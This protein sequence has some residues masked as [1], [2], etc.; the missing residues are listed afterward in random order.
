MIARSIDPS[1]LPSDIESTMGPGLAVVGT[2]GSPWDVARRRVLLPRPLGDSFR[3]IVRLRSVAIYWFVNQRQYYHKVT[4]LSTLDSGSH[5]TT[6]PWS[7]I[8]YPHADP[9]TNTIHRALDIILSG[10]KWWSC[11]IYLGGLIEF[12]KKEAEHVSHVDRVLLLLRGQGV[13]LRYVCAGFSQDDIPAAPNQTGADLRD[14][15]PPERFARGPQPQDPKA[16]P[17]IYRDVQR[18]PTLRV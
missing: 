12:S 3:F 18:L 10:V 7:R 2:P 17:G 8:P 5:S 11:L 9:T 4:I 14:A 6:S 1:P 13:T 15:G 16:S